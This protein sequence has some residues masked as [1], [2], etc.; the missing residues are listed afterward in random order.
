MDQGA[1]AANTLREGPCVARV[2]APQYDFDAAHHR[3]RTRRARD[4]R[5]VELRLDPQMPFDS[6]DRIDDDGLCAHGEC[7]ASVKRC[8]H[9][10]QQAM[11]CLVPAEVCL[12][13][14]KGSPAIGAARQ[15]GSGA[16][17]VDFAQLVLH[18]PVAQRG[19]ALDVE[20]AAAAAAAEAEPA[21]ILQLIQLDTHRLHESPRCI[22]DAAL[23]HQL[24]RIVESGLAGGRRAQPR[25]PACSSSARNSVT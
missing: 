11:G 6:R 17:V 13:I 22:V 5:S 25:R 9:Q 24:A 2:A 8:C 19:G 4:R 20:Y 3:S 21:V 12:C 7:P 18:G 15:E 1:H 14:V 16:G 10:F 23:A